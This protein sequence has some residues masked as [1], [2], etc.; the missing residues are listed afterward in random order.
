[1]RS[2]MERR[3]AR[4]IATRI[5]IVAVLLAGGCAAVSARA[6]KLQVL[7]REQLM[8]HGDEQWRRLVELRPRRGPITDRNGETLAASADAPSIAANPASL[9]KLPRAQLL[10]LARALALD[11]SILEKKAQRPAHF[12]WLKRRVAPSEAKAAKDLGLESVDVF[13]E[14][15]R[16]YTSKGLAAQLL[17]FVGDDGEGLEGIEAAFDEELQGGPVRLTS[18]RDARGR[19]VFLGEVP[20]SGAALAGARVELTIDVG[21][22]LAAE[23][24]LS[25]AVNQA[26]AVAGMLV[27]MDPRTGEV[28]ALANA[29]IVNPNLPRKVGTLRD[30]AILDTFEPGSTAKIFTIAGALDAGVL[31]KTD[32]IDCEKGA[33]RI[34]GHVIHDHKALGWADA[35]R[36]I[37]ASSNVGAA[38][39]GARLGRE[40]LQQTLLSFGFGERSG[41][42]LSGEPRGAVPFPSSEVAVA[43]MSFGQGVAATPL[44]ITSATAAIANRGILMKPIVV[45]RVVDMTSGAILSQLEPTPI[46]RAV[47]Q[48]SVAMLTKWLEGVV[49]DQDGTGKR[50]RLALW[51]VAGKTGTAQKVDPITHRYSTDKRFSSFVGFAPAEAPRIAVGVFIDE[52]RG[53]VYGGEV[54]APVFRE[55]AE[56]A[57]KTLGVPPSEGAEAPPAAP[58]PTASSGTERV[59]APPIEEPGGRPALAG[60]VAVPAVVGMPARSALRTLENAELTGEIQGSGRVATQSP[61]PGQVVGRGARVRLLLSPTRS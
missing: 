33:Y 54:A 18:L 44:Q 51:R 46:R 48:Q 22:Q 21:I 1:M 34:G 38:K 5:A 27:A 59:S 14:P 53:E 45:R 23:Q 42:G 11:P 37:A 10:R 25:R 39:I 57:L 19:S 16:Y 3:Q 13:D 2:G 17:G 36:I 49:T 9:A 24:A 20:F 56:R 52:P 40:R 7:Q 28:L 8:K 31:R 12:V 41:T 29:P 15:R 43:T 6:V 32:A 60:R 35:A 30:R 4:W 47:T 58:V 55:V 61:A 26:H 50:A